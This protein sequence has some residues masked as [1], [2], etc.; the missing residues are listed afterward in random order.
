PGLRRTTTPSP[1]RGRGLVATAT[2]PP[3]SAIAVFPNPLL[4]LPDGDHVRRV[5]DW[6]LVPGSLT[7]SPSSASPSSTSAAQV[8]RKLSLC[9]RCRY[10]SYCSR[11]C[12]SAAWKAVHKLECPALCRIKDGKW[13]VPTPVRAAMQLLLRL[14]QNDRAVRDAIGDVPGEGEKEGVL[15]SNVEGFREY[16]DGTVW[17]DLGAQAAAALRF[18]GMEGEGEAA[19]EGVK[20]VLCMLQTNAFDR[21]DEDVGAAGVFLDA[22]LAMANHSCV[23]NAYVVFVGRTAVLRAEREIREGEEVEISYIDNTLSKEERHKALRLYHF[24]CQCRR[25]QDDLDIYQVCQSSSTIPLNIFSLQPDLELYANP[26]INRTALQTSPPLLTKATDNQT[27]GYTPQQ[28]REK[29]KLLLEA[30]AYAI[31]PLPSVLHDLLIRHETQDQN[32]AYA[33]SLACFLATHCHPFGHPAPFK[34]WRVK[35]LMMIAQL[36]SQTAPLSATGELGRTCPDA[37]LVQRLSRMDQVSVCE[38]VLRLVVHY[39]PVAHSDEWEVV[40]SAR[41]LL[42]DIAQL[43][44]RERESAVIGAWAGSPGRPEARAFFEEVVLRPI[45]ELAGFAVGILERELLGG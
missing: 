35:G 27:K 15:L 14:R 8:E 43:R 45:R 32:F 12:Q 28:L 13:F 36:L 31:E 22:D 7:T 1:S 29:C 2:F 21:R 33:L 24:E 44:G 19:A 4:C 42:D 40:V 9:T 10:V 26:P 34:P 20:R 3:G 30:K 41:E 17:K 6:C 25:C 16:G 37:V 23:P 11:K 18:S 5:C 39:G 38:A